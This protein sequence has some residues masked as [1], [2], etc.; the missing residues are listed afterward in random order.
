MSNLVGTQIDSQE[1]ERQLK[2]TQKCAILILYFGIINSKTFD[3]GSIRKD[4]RQFCEK[5][6]KFAEK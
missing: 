4:S 1:F 3:L 5:M 6:F 2:L